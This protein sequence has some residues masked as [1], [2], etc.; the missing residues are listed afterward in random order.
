MNLI[1]E[2]DEYL[3]NNLSEKRYKHC[4]RVMQR[5][6]EL[7]KIH[8]EDVE[9]AKIC[10]LAHDIAKEMSPKETFEYIKHNKIRID[11]VERKNVK[12][13]HGK[14]GADIVKKKFGFSDDMQK[15]IE[16]HTTTNPKMDNLAKIVYIADKTE[17]GR[18]SVNYKIDYEREL[19][20][21][22][23]DKALIFIIEE[24][25]TH[26]FEKGRL[27]H[28]KCIETRNRIITKMNKKEKRNNEC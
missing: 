22:D 25:V 8:G 4:V 12:L 21:K 13:L 23:L 17:D 11:K 10:G 19:A 18:S 24:S 14:I 28:P 2:I 6:E 27:V 9:K 20:N 26:L 7:A 5:A 15:A 3:K 1:D 16:Y